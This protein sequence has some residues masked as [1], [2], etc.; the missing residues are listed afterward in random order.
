MPLAPGSKLGPYEIQALLGKGGMGEVY[1]ARDTRLHRDVALK[2]LPPEFLADRSRRDRFETEAKAVAALNHPNIVGLYDIAEAD[3]HLFT[4]SELIDG[5]TLRDASL[6]LRKAL[7][8]AAQ[9]ADGLAAAHAKGVTH[10]DLKPDNVMLTRD[11]RAKILD[12][13]LAQLTVT[14]DSDATKTA[15]GMVMGTAGY[16]SPEQVRGE[17]VDTR[18]D[19]FSFGALLYELL[20]NKRAFQ[21]QTAVESMSAILKEDPPELPA[22][23]P[24]AVR[25]IVQTCLEK[26]R[27]QRFQS[28][29]DLAFALRQS[30]NATATAT[31]TPAL[32]K[33][34]KPR[35]LLWMGAAT[36]PLAA[37]GGFLLAQ[38][39][40][41]PVDQL[42][43]T[44]FTSGRT[45]KMWPAFSPDGRSIAYLQYEGGTGHLVV[46]TASTAKPL[47]LAQGPTIDPPKWTA[48]GYRVCYP[49]RGAIWCVG[50]AG[51]TPQ[52]VLEGVSEPTVALVQGAAYFIRTDAGK[53]K[54]YVS[55]PLGAA[56]RSLDH[57]VLPDGSTLLDVSTDAHTA[58]VSSTAA[59]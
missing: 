37:L 16:M 57:V 33:P 46:Q 11:G 45:S 13:G 26:A 24:Q 28:A 43:I 56:P 1:K 25:N 15:T 3:G 52:R 36:I 55:S 18:S 39:G 51:G 4:I 53:S 20:A 2:L 5:A 17:A 35:R 59:L 41:E 48:D 22:A 12:F 19:I 42:R 7:D 49:D 30:I 27:E 50:S 58:L 54:L 47:V 23:I 32:T 44:P 34:T 40:S 21:A 6:P 14:K 38:Y 29:K 31:D 9:I 8:V 10:R